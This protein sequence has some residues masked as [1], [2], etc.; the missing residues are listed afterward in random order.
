MT[1]RTEPKAVRI[2]SVVAAALMSLAVPGL[3][4]ASAV[5]AAAQVAAAAPGAF[6][7]RAD[8]VEGRIAYL[9]AELKI[10]DAQAPQWDAVASAMR[11][12]AEAER[13]LRD[14]MH[15]QDGKPMTAVERLARRD[16]ANAIHTENA[17]AFTAAFTALYAR[18]GDDQKKAADQ[19]LSP[20]RHRRL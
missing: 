10:T 14:E 5:P 4:V 15:A 18:M 1:V 12:G 16:K 7:G 20:R 2:R 9:R 13:A 3:I 19:L 8:H 17:K 11:R 6:H